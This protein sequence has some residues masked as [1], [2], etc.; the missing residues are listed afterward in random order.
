MPMNIT[1]PTQRL[2][3]HARAPRMLATGVGALL[4]AW[5]SLA[6]ALSAHAHEAHAPPPPPWQAASPWPD[7]IVATLP[8][9]PASSFAVTWRTDASVTA[10]NAELALA[11]P[12]A[13]FDLTATPHQAVS[14]VLD[15]ARVERLGA[16]VEVSWNTEL[17][18]V[19]FHSVRFE[20]LAPDT[21]YAYRVQGRDDRWSEWFQLRTAPASGP[22]QFIYLGD[23]Q[24]GILSHWSRTVR[25][26]FQH[27]PEARFILHA[28]DLVNRAS[29]DFEWAEWFRAVGFIHGMIPAFPVA[30]N[31]EYDRIGLPEGASRRML[32]ILWRPQFTL[33]EVESLPDLLRETVYDVRYNED[34]HL[35]VLDTQGGMI[36]EQA[37][38]LD[39]A[40]AASDARW[41]LVSMHHPAFS[42]GRGRDNAE[43]REILLPVLLKH[44]VDL[45]LQGHDHTYARGAIGPLASD[46]AGP[47]TP[48][49]LGVGA[50]GEIR[51]MFVNSVSGAKQYTFKEDRWDGYAEHD[52]ELERF[53]ENTQFYQI[54]EVDGERL[55]Y[56]AYTATGDLYDH[57]VISKPEQ[58]PKRVTTGTRPLADPRMFDGTLPYPGVD[59][60]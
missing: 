26:A 40:L 3:V 22:V 7:R 9:D 15:P 25:A 49:R 42:S 35:F 37:E 2:L 31:H 28:G 1:A 52:V 36:V 48:E 10:P 51:S 47:Q 45:V 33:P 6:A 39:G 16:V 23:A 53:A 43:R 44:E 20:G 46:A 24:N 13:R 56:E 11:T 8:G 29:R 55:E 19:H 34:I 4:L 50:D 14:E 58:G 32:S 30:G 41:K 60:L 27:A 38:W 18:P 12:D 54:I 21:L 57:F 17:A 5:L 59:D